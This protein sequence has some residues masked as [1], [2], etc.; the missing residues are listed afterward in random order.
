MEGIGSIMSVN[1]NSVEQ[2]RRI[3]KGSF[4]PVLQRARLLAVGV[5]VV[6]LGSLSRC[7]IE[8]WV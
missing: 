7:T 5:L 3:V 1:G 8:T 4:A 6:G 2:R